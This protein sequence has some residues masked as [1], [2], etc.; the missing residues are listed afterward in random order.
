MI[1][2][3]QLDL[4]FNNVFR[5][6]ITSYQP[7]SE[8]RSNGATGSDVE[9]ILAFHELGLQDPVE[10]VEPWDV[11]L[12]NA[13]MIQR[14]HNEKRWKDELTDLQYAVTRQG[15]TER[16]FTGEYDKHF[17]RSVQLYLLWQKV[18]HL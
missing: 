6:T 12:H 4:D 2:C 15:A 9:R 13:L 18:V 17:E 16:P 5:N 8:G 11:V 3:Q 1:S 10:Y 7:D 14:E